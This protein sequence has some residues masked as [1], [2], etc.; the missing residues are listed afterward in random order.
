MF[1]V[2]VFEIGRTDTIAAV[3]K[4]FRLRRH[5]VEVDGRAE[6]QAITTG[7][8]AVDRVEGIIEE[9]E[10]GSRRFAA[11]LAGDNVEIPESDEGVT[12]R[13]G[14]IRRDGGGDPLQDDFRR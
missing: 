5:G 12:Y 8:L 14:E 6:Q 1:R 11:S 10:A 4:R 9:T 7:Q 13:V 3:Y 2:D